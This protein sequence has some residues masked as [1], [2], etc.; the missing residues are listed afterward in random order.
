MSNEKQPPQIFAGVEW[1]DCGQGDWSLSVGCRPYMIF[2][3]GGG[4]DAKAIDTVR[5]FPN[6][7]QEDYCTA[8]YWIREQILRHYSEYLAVVGDVED[9]L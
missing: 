3:A 8:A 1:E 2:A 6:N 7:R 5:S 9:E 4:L